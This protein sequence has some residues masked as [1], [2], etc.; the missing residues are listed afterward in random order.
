MRGLR[1]LIVGTLIASIVGV[2]PG[3]AR[4]TAEARYVA[5]ELLPLFPRHV[6]DPTGEVGTIGVGG[7]T[8]PGTDRAPRRIRIVDDVFGAGSIGAFFVF[9]QSVDRVGTCT[10]AD[11]WIDLRRFGPTQAGQDLTVEPLVTGLVYA[12]TG[13]CEN[14]ASTGTITVEY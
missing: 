10:D 12:D 1:F 4:P 5:G 9:Q 3:S 7:V 11:G 6:P 13:A 8:F 2:V 14:A